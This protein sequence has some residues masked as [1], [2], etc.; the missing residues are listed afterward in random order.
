MTSSALPE[1]THLAY[2]IT[3]EA[4]YA[5]SLPDDRREINIAA[6]AEGS[7]GGVAWE[8][9]VEE[10]NLGSHGPEIRVK[11]LDDAFAA[12][13]Q[14]PQFFAALEAENVKGLDEVRH[15]LDKM[16]A[17]DETE[18]RGPHGVTRPVTT[19]ERIRR[20][21]KDAADAEDATVAVLRTLGMEVDSR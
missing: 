14:I 3:H 10:V 13:T 6:S 18:R 20:A 7:G 5:R 9:T 11:V 19:A 21:I 2:T 15:L 17:T 1:D 8:F 12:F 16:G 4:W